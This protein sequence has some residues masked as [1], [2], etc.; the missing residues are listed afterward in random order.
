MKTIQLITMKNLFYI[1]LLFTAFANAQIVPI[2]DANFKAKLLS[3]DVT[4]QIAYGNG[5]YMKI[6]VNEDG[7][8]QEL[9]AQAVDSLNVYN[10]N[11]IDL[12]GITSFNNLKKLD[13]SNN[14]IA[15][16][17][18]INNIL[19]AELFCSSNL[20][21]NLNLNGLV[22]LT[23]IYC[24]GNQLTNL[25]LNGLSNLN[26]LYVGQNFI[27]SLSINGSETSLVNLSCDFNLLNTIDVSPYINLQ[28][29]NC[30]NNNLNTLVVS[31]LENL[32]Y[33]NCGSN[34]LATL[35][36]TSLVELTHLDISNNFLTTIDV[37]NNSL[38]ANFKGASN[39]FTSLNLNNNFNLY[40]IDVIQNTNLE[41][42]FINNG[43]FSN[44]PSFSF[45]GLFNCPNLIYICVQEEGIGY[46]TNEVEI[47]SGASNVVINSYCS[48]TPGG[49]Y[50]TI[51]G[52]IQF[53]ANNDG[54]DLSD[55]PQLNIKININDGTNQGAT[56]N[57]SAGNYTFY[58]DAGSFEITPNVEN[59]T[60]FTFSPTTA[61]IPFA[62]TNNN[63]TTQNFC[64]TANGVHPD[65]EMVIVPITP[66]RPGFD[67]VYKVVYKNKGNQTVQATINFNYNDTLLDFVSSSEVAN[68]NA[69]GAMS[70]IIPTLQPFQSGSIEIVLNVNSPME[71]PAVT[72][73]DVLVFTSF[74]DITTDEN[75]ADNA[76]TLNQVV[77]GSFDP[78]DITCLEGD[79]ISPSEI[80]NYLHYN[81]RFE[82]TGTA[83]AE[84]IVVKTEV[85]AAD[86]DINSL[87]MLATSHNAYT[88]IKGNKIEFI[89][90]NIMLDTGGHGNVLLKIRSKPSLV[91]GDMVSKKADIFF[92]YNFPIITND[93]E[94]VFQSLSNPIF[95]IDS[96][97]T[98]YPNPSKSVVNI[99]ADST[100][101]SLQLYDIQGRL[102]QTNLIDQ[103]TTTLDISSK[104]SGVY[105]LKVI[106]EKGIKAEKIVKE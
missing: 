9:E 68:G 59:P 57:N 4:N 84:N 18:L 27:T 28:Y 42:L 81:I 8:I 90:E 61:T 85:N 67:A 65:V 71:T 87:Q 96:S 76:F 24:N 95:E 37:S 72:I 91:T 93:A 6:D 63:S 29:L 69:N 62:D 44:L 40:G 82:N 35:D 32:V 64:I 22:N 3:A 54:C 79:I 30:S 38:L 49:N 10:S 104:V 48:F 15:S 88:R 92:D 102:L 98:V 39:L 105:F 13:C 55:L 12:I 45:L 66:A 41:V 16:L 60:W 73:N 36:I 100:I 23:S 50:N 99:K 34:Q 97:I 89:F 106:S 86:F 46:V 51:N 43:I 2:P 1:T 103:T 75:F 21:P 70:W 77:V 5:G 7:E 52:L 101:K 25:N 56:F 74:I 11:I 58:T 83:A 47:N 20:L 26:I 17:D 78:N 94:T 31:T 14:Q 53:D 80:G 19:L 33:L